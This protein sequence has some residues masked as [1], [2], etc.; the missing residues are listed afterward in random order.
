[1]SL[2]VLMMLLTISVTVSAADNND[3]VKVSE[4]SFSATMRGVKAYLYN[5]KPLDG[6]VG[7]EMYLTYTVANEGL[8]Q[9]TQHGIIGSSDP[10][11]AYPYSNGGLMYYKND[12]VET[13]LRPGYTYFFKFVITE[14]GFDYTV[15]CAK[16]DES[17]VI[18]FP[19]IA[20]TGEGEMKYIGFWFEG[21]KG[22][23]I[24]LTNI[25]CYDKDGNDLGIMGEQ[26]YRMREYST[27]FPKSKMNH[28]YK[29]TVD[30]QTDVNISNQKKSM[31][32]EIYFEYTVASSTS[33][34]YQT[35]IKMNAASTISA[36]QYQ[37][38]NMP[39]D[40]P[41]NGPMLIPGADYWVRCSNTGTH[42]G[43][44]ALIQRTYQGKTEW[45]VFTSQVGTIFDKNQGFCSLVFGEGTKYKATFVLDDMRCYDAKGNN[46]GVKVSGKGIVEHTGELLDY[47]GCRAVYYC[48]ENQQII[49]LEDNKNMSHTDTEG[50]TKTGKY[51]IDDGKPLVMTTT[52]GKEKAEYTYYRTYLTDVDGNRYERLRTYKVKFVTGTK[53]S[54]PTQT[55]STDTGYRVE[56]PENPVKEN[57]SFLYWCTRDGEEFDFSKIGTASVTLYAKW[58]YDNDKTFVRAISEIV[59]TMY[60]NPIAAIG[61][62]AVIILGSITTCIVLVRRVK[63][64]E[65]NTKKK[66]AN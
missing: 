49:A 28:K 56:K 30:K 19:S 50:L 15:G 26:V 58:K 52:I 10:T 65:N 44:E 66:K 4:E 51:K 63:K 29:V 18:Y 23:N 24:Q 55:L 16:G 46:L 53:D 60:L 20:G 5:E 62:S 37:Y 54:I 27:P 47:S 21:L 64:D 31:S 13:L 9:A 57:D 48:K 38:E 42:K 12:N 41:G 7:T 43:W 33:Q 40:Q 59:E 32:D 11:Q 1:M 17:K 8:I 35:G 25:H 36:G 3:K 39:F 22:T 61:V 6:K 2:L 34:I 14:T 45:F